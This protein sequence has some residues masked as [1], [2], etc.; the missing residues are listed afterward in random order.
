LSRIPTIRIKS[1]NPAHDGGFFIRNH[2]DLRYGE[3]LFKADEFESLGEHEI[4]LMLESSPPDEFFVAEATLW[5]ELKAKEQE[6]SKSA[7]REALEE[8]S[9][10]I[11]RKDLKNSTRSNK[12]AISAI[13]IAAIATIIAAIIGVKFGN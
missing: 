5:L 12:I 10:S 9:L 4:R 3:E 1:K 2:D 6:F 8:E 13:V 11:A 7:R